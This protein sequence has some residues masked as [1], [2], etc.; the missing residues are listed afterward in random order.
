MDE[1]TFK[2]YPRTTAEAF[3]PLHDNGISGP[4]KNE[5]KMDWQDQVVVW[6]CVVAAVVSLGFTLWG[7]FT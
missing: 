5:N 2:K 1:P 3:K 4:A 7:R 6:G